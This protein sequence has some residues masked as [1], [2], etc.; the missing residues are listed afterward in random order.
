MNMKLDV[1]SLGPSVLTPSRR[2]PGLQRGSHFVQLYDDDLSLV[3]AV[4]TFISIGL[5]VGDAAIIV[6]DRAHRDAFEGAL[7]ASGVDVRGAADRGLLLSLD[8]EAMLADFMVDEMPDGEKFHKLFGDLIGQATEGGRNV[9][10]FGEMVSVLWAEGNVAGAVNLEEM[11]NGLAESYPFRLFCAYPSDAFAHD[12]LSPLRLICHQH[13]K[14]I[15]PG[16]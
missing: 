13:S 2:A 7:V 1:G 4:R 5:S 10:V 3:D 15:P 12:T 11:W 9:R 16:R 6:A 8:A 14:V